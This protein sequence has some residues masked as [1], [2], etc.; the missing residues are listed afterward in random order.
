MEYER[1]QMTAAIHTPWPT[2][3]K[4]AVRMKRAIVGE[5]ERASGSTDCVKSS[6]QA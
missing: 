3:E 4:S 1:R 5:I 6:S 2:G